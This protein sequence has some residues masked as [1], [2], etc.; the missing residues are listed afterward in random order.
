MR[1][2]WFFVLLS[3]LLLPGCAAGLYKSDEPVAVAAGAP[4]TQAAQHAKNAEQAIQKGDM[5]A[6]IA[7]LEQAVALDAT[8]PDYYYSLGVGYHNKSRVAEARAA[9]LKTIEVAPEPKQHTPQLAHAYYNLGC[10]SA[11]AGNADEAFDWLGKAVDAFFPDVAL[12]RS[13]PDL[14]SLRK[15]FRY[16][17]LLALLTAKLGQGQGQGAP[18]APIAPVP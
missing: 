10:L 4:Q 11:V 18:E 6:A 15:D 13:D 3:V 12:F 2:G 8:R 14:E 7:A 1:K 16:Q 5:D 17:M 9:Y